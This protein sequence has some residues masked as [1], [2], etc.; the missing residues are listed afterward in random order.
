MVEVIS[1]EQL[2]NSFYFS[3]MNNPPNLVPY[4]ASFPY[5]MVEY[6][7]KIYS[8]PYDTV[9][10]PHCG[11]G[12]TLLCALKNNRN[13]IGN[14][15]SPLALTVSHSICYPVS[16]S[17]IYEVLGYIENCDRNFDSECKKYEDEIGILYNKDT[18]KEI[19]KARTILNNDKFVFSSERIHRAAFILRAFM[20][21]LLLKNNSKISFNGLHIRSDQVP[22]VKTLLKIYRL[23]G[24]NSREKIPYVDIYKATRKRIKEI[25]FN[26]YTESVS[27][28]KTLLTSFS[29]TNIKLLKDES[30]DFIFTS[31]PYLNFI[32]YGKN[33]WIRFWFIDNR[34]DKFITNIENSL[35]PNNYD[36]ITM[37]IGSTSQNINKYMYFTSM[38]LKE[39]YRVLKNNRFACIVI[40]DYEDVDSNTCAFYKM[41]SKKLR[42]WKLLLERAEAIGFKTVQV[43]R[44]KLHK[45]SS[46]TY[47]VNSRSGSCKYDVIVVLQKGFAE[48]RINDINSIDFSWKNS[49][50]LSLCDF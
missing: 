23:N 40:G 30:V 47:N 48:Y 10:D 34:S 7:M 20:S 45:T 28:L 19:I 50:Q 6:F 38:Y 26:R 29:S 24:V 49:S 35:T 41:S 1:S 21:E 4:I 11:R 33:N 27:D 8:K 46:S 3:G 36:K 37:K 13:A 25:D 12:T 18:W 22:S 31:P 44:T 9:L 14:D 32:N 42:I 5:N 43:V 17:D 16:E 15:L 2:K 39:M